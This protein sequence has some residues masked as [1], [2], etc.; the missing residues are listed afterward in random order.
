MGEE[1]VIFVGANEVRDEVI[2]DAAENAAK[3]ELCH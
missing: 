3:S 2:R 1:L